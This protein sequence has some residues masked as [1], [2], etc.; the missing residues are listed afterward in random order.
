MTLQRTN[1]WIGPWEGGWPLI[2][3]AAVIGGAW[4]AAR[5]LD[6]EALSQLALA[7]TL[8]LVAWC[9]LWRALIMTPWKT[10]F[11]RWKAWDQCVPLPRLP[12]IQPHTPGAAL[13]RTLEQ[14]H[15][16][17]K[18]EGSAT[19]G[20]PLGSALLALIAGI[21][22]S[23]PLGRTALLLTLIHFAWVQLMT[24]WSEGSGKPGRVGEAVAAAGLPWLLGASLSEGALPL[25]GSLAVIALLSFY[26]IPGLPALL[27]PMLAAGYLLSQGEPLATGALLLLALPGLL[28][29]TQRF[30]AA[31]YRFAIPPWVIAMLLLMGWVL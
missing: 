25:G 12:F 7:S 8:V 31:Q 14:A 1:P 21:L 5:P 19:L 15:A 11:A 22:L 16:W 26:P 6:A 18:S 30:P 2:P 9:P 3:L 29:L 13:T 10:P 17:W 24:L 27:G 4:E 28:L 23:L 20:A